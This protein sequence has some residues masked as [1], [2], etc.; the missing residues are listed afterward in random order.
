MFQSLGD[1]ALVYLAQQLKQLKDTPK[2]Q[3]KEKI[4]ELLYQLINKE[5]NGF[6]V[7]EQ[8]HLRWSITRLVH[9]L[10]AEWDAERDIKT[11]A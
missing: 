8:G 10:K 4:E 1:Q 11:K 2:S 6:Y 9:Q 7:D 3:V 5:A